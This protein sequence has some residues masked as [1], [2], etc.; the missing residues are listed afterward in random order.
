MTL[1]DAL[2]EAVAERAARSR[3][4]AVVVGLFWTIVEVE[5]E[6]RPLAGLAASLGSSNDHH[7]GAG[8]PVPDA[9]HLLEYGVPRL[10]AMLR[11]PRLAEAS[12]GMAAI[13][14]LLDV[15][16]ERTVEVN[17]ADVII[18]RGRGKRI[19]IVGHFPFTPQVREAAARLWVLERRPRAGDLPAEQ[20]PAIIPQA[21]VVAITGTTLVNHTL[22]ALLPLCREDAFV[23]VMGGTTPVTPLLFDFGIDAVAGTVLTRPEAARRAA[24][25][26][27][28]YRQLPGKKL[29]TLFREEV[30]APAGG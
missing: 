18:E 3:P 19:A 4:R 7:Y 2:I 27:A 5:L 12:I 24:A 11:S 22:E 29:Y 1:T 9:G 8:F 17:A 6:G 16:V 20:A 10:T 13:N 26:G 21:D 25:E 23:I 30:S 15:P 14:A 28:T